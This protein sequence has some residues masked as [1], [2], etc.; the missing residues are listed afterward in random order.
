MS[1]IFEW[2][3][4]LIDWIKRRPR[5]AVIAAAVLIA[6][7]VLLV[8]LVKFVIVPI[9]VAAFFVYLLFED[10]IDFGRPARP[11]YDMEADYLVCAAMI[12]EAACEL[13]D[14]LPVSPLDQSDL[15][16]RM[17][18]PIVQSPG[19]PKYLYRSRKK[20]GVGMLD[21]DALAEEA[22]LLNDA[23]QSRQCRG[24]AV[25]KDGRLF[26]TLE[27]TNAASGGMPPP[28]DREF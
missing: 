20:A 17:S 1:Y 5:N 2:L 11:G 4:A 6:A 27:L 25:I 26:Q 23:L 13:H 12:Y 28:Y 3:S 9:C 14:A 18:N 24:I 21:A 7:V 8:A 19:G 15:Y 22:A 16:P 10:K